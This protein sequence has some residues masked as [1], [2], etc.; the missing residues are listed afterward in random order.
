MTA[1]A[2]IR[3]YS[4]WPV[5]LSEQTALIEEHQARSFVLTI[6]LIENAIQIC[7]LAEHLSNPEFANRTELRARTLYG[8]IALFWSLNVPSR[9]REELDFQAIRL[10]NAIL[11]LEAKKRCIEASRRKSKKSTF[12]TKPKEATVLK[13]PAKKLSVA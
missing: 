7:A 3:N 5:L 12:G 11:H 8:N 4:D 13:F 1:K 10:K 6:K 2:A 9:Y